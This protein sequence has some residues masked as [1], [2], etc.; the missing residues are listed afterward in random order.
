MVPAVELLDEAYRWAEKLA[1]LPPMHV[2]RTKALMRG[3]RSMPSQK[4]LGLERE[5]RE[6]LMNLEDSKEAV[7][8]WNERRLPLYKGR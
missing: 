4:M 3:M 8:A 2:R 7:L 6:Y 1:K 5:A